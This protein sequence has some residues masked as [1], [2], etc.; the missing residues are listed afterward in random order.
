MRIFFLFLLIGTVAACDRGAGPEADSRRAAEGAPTAAY[1]RRMIFVGGRE[2]APAIVIFDHLALAGPT[3][4]E[5]RV[6]FWRTTAEGWSPL[7]D[8]KWSD[9]PIREPWRLVPHGAFR[10]LVDDAGEVE[11][12]IGRGE[13]DPFQLMASGRIGEWSPDEPPQFRINRGAWAIGKDT[14][15]GLL[16]DI[17]PG[18]ASGEGA[19]G[20]SELVLTNGAEF[21]L[22]ARLPMTN[23]G[24]LWLQ[25]G[26]RMETMAGVELARAAE[27]DTSAPTVWHIGAA[28]GEIMGELQPAGAA[29]ELRYEP[30]A[31][32]TPATTPGTP[33]GTRARTPNGGGALDSVALPANQPPSP[34]NLQIV[35]GWIEVRGDRRQVFGIMRRAPA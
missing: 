35:K 20:L 6:G 4:V 30:V 25:R 14:I 33:E 23:P 1:A 9:E 28:H 3:A 22:V 32:G 16:V 15:A 10:F 13:L 5:R 8:L 7:L 2:A 26:E 19:T 12:L 18:V 34:A 17:Q 31:G 24:E 11:A 21:H 29:L 27:S